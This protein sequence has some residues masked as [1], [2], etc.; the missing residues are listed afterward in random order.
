MPENQPLSDHPIIHYNEQAANRRGLII[1]LT[2]ELEKIIELRIGYYFCK[3]E[4]LR[5][6]LEDL[7]LVNLQLSS[8]IKI[9]T[10]LYRTHSPEIFQAHPKL[11]KDLE[12]IRKYR[13]ELAHSWLDTSVT[14]FQNRPKFKPAESVFKNKGKSVIYNEARVNEIRALIVKYSHII[15][16]WQ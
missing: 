12:K 7:V 10:S 14:F 6:E 2:I 15:F 8:K 13:N 4:K 11:E 1:N 9:I 16:N 3:D 5:E